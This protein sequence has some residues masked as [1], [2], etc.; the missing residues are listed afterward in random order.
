MFVVGVTGGIGCGKTSVTDYLAGKGIIIADA[1]QAARVVVM[2]GQP[3]LQSIA[4][5]F[6]ENLILPDGQLNR[7]ALRDIIFDNE[8]ER[9]WLEQLLHP[10]IFQ[11]INFELEQATSPYVVLVSP[12]LIETSQHQ[13]VNRILV[14]DV[15]EET[16]IARTMNRDGVPRE[17]AEAILRSQS[18][19]Q[20]RLNKADDVV[21]NS[22]S[23]EQLHQQ[24][25]KLHQTYLDMAAS[26]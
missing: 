20:N 4:Q 23:L 22:G 24:L 13:L 14:I 11:Q 18:D 25:D 15:S 10:L 19:R 8:T 7:R 9:R 2:P 17:Q 3:A 16:Q 5:H 1:D 21:D 12:L 6:G 26:N